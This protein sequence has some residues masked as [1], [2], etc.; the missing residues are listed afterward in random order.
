MKK[1]TVALLL[2]CLMFA[3]AGMAEVIPPAMNRNIPVHALPNNPAIPGVSSTTGLPKESN[4]YA[5]ILVQVDNNPG[6]L[7]HFG[8]GAADIMYELPIQGNGWTR[9]TALF[10]DQYPQEAGPVRSGRVMHADLREE[11]DALFVFFGKQEV[12]GSDLRKSLRDYGVNQKGL[13]FDGIGNKYAK[14]FQRTKYHRAPHNVAFFVQ[15][16]YN[17]LI[18]PMNYPFPVRPFLFTDEKPAMGMAAAKVGIIH[19]GNEET[20]STFEYNA[21]SNTYTR[22]TE[23]GPYVDLFAPETPIQYANIIVMR[24]RLTFNGNTMNPLL[25]DIIGQGACEIFTAGQYIPGEWYRE[26]P[27]SRTIFFDTNGSEIQ[28][29]RGKTWICITDENSQIS[30]DGGAVSAPE[31]MV[32]NN[33]DGASTSGT[34]AYADINFNFMKAPREKIVQYYTA[35]KV[36]GIDQTVYA[37]TDTQGATQFRVYG[38]L[39]GESEGFYSVSLTKNADSEDSYQMEIDARKPVKD[40]MVFQKYT[41]GEA[42]AASLPAGFTKGQGNGIYTFNNLFNKPEN[43]SYASPDGVNFSWYF[44]NVRRPLAGSLEVDMDDVQARMLG[45]DGVVYTQPK[46]MRSGYARKVKI[47]I[48]DGSEVSV[49]TDFPIIDKTQ[50]TAK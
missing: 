23:K 1:I 45:E 31:Y 2:L 19:K 34:K 9:L 18:A 43:L 44:V 16:A 47:R 25:P 40:S 38:R 48:A 15:N 39:P 3:A 5:P 36:P 11:W 20:S 22:F 46:E 27:S 14:Y 4:T 50:L 6:A 41:P 13:A 28:L 10:A 35:V 33:A 29:Q 12:G 32:Q 17:D 37:F 24:T 21:E 7:P 42:D 30:I 49:Y 26:M 8:V